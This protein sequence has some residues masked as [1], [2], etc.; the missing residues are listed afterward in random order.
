MM[1]AAS[2]CC[3]IDTMVGSQFE[4]GL[5]ALKSVTEHGATRSADALAAAE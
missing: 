1:K 4:S 5:A 2:L 3:N